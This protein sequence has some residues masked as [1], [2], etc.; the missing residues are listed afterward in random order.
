MIGGRPSRYGGRL[1]SPY[2]RYP[3]LVGRALAPVLFVLVFALGASR[4]ATGT[5]AAATFTPGTLPAL[6][7]DD[8]T[9]RETNVDTFAVLTVTLAPASS[10]AVTV[11]Y[12]TVAGTADLTDY[13][14]ASGVAT[15]APGVTSLRLPVAIKADALDEPDETFFVD[16]TS[17]TNAT[18]SRARGT[19]TIIDDDSPSPPWVDA[20][21]AAR[22][23]VHRAYTRVAQLV[24][25]RASAGASVTVACAGRG[26]PFRFK[27][28]GLRLTRLFAGARLRPGA[29]IQV[30]V[31]APL[32]LGKRFGFRIRARKPPL[33]TTT[34]L[35]SP[36]T[37]C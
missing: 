2:P 34:C 14:A 29:R 8:V 11:A 12:A 9:T 23:E 7:I 27:S 32:T 21:L 1:P 30:T 17:A 19:V 3:L 36:P 22:W 28:S 13:G 20:A 35:S 24:V 5:P 18:V 33:R 4:A 37:S 6:A 16:L 15:L 10:Q 31:D 26:C 25:S